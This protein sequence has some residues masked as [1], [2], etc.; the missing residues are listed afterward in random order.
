MN[1]MIRQEAQRLLAAM[2]RDEKI[3]LV[4]GVDG[5][6]T[7]G[8]PRLGVRKLHMADASIGLRDDA[9]PATAFPASIALAATWNRDQAAA[10]GQAVA[11]EFRA[12]GMDVLLGPGVN[13]YRT[14]C[15]GRNFEYLGEDP[16]LAS[17]MVTAY[18]RAAQAEGVSTTVKHFA[19]NNSD[20]HRC[21]SNSVVD[22]RTLRE[23][24]LPAFEAAVKDGGTRALM[25][26][27]NLLNGEY[28]A[29]NRW[30]SHK[31]LREDWGFDGLVMS[32]WNGTRDLG[33]AFRAGMDLDMPGVTQWNGYPKPLRD[34]LD[35][36][37]LKLE[38]LDRSVF[39][40]LA[41]TLEIQKMQEGRARPPRGKCADHAAVA[42][43]TAREGMVLLR[44]R[45]NLLPLNARPGMRLC[46]VGPAANPTPPS[47]GGAAEVKAVD[48]VSILGAVCALA[49]EA[50]VLRTDRAEE[51][52]KADAVIVCVGYDAEREREGLDRPWEL[53]WHRDLNVI[54][55]CQTHNPNTIVVI[56]AGGGVE[57]ASWIDKTA[58]V[59]HAWYPGENGCQAIAE[60][61]F[62]KINP[63]GRLPITIE[64]SWADG[65]AVS[66]YLPPGGS[67]YNVPDFDW[68]TRAVFDVNYEEGVFVG[69]RHFDRTG[70][71]PLFP[72]GFGLSYT[73][74]AYSA[75]R[76]KPNAA[77]GADVTFRVRNT[78]ARAGAEVAQVYVGDVQASVPRPVKEL[79]GFARLVLEPGQEQETTVTLDRRAFAF[80]DVARQEWVVEPGEFRI[81]VGSSAQEMR[82]EGKLV[83]G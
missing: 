49:P 24:Y 54:R 22:E 52:A 23:V 39:Q 32:D 3:D 40:I 61:L 12:A 59:L 41:W 51:L 77:G 82:L 2:T 70:N 9:I 72:F 57:M 19:A 80:F 73:T 58:A 31:V 27:Y 1:D 56:V 71:A 42:L 4:H 79:K 11:E 18:I 30:L 62:G 37:A 60:I 64:R 83:T 67:H 66:N 26:S 81:W 15:C 45:D 7:R 78:G 69:H 35:S 74:F 50:T 5:M 17:Q 44:N 48:P 63:S 10:Y 68:P 8:V 75:L 28:T 25:T 36:G 16:C 76:V 14:A 53:H 6:W 47:G 46:V 20:W 33:K 65:A 55:H 13:M 21:C 29:C 34:L 38:E 43:Q